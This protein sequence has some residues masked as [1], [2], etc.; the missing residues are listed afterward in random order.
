M[1]FVTGSNTA[2]GNSSSVAAITTAAITG[3][4]GKPVIAYHVT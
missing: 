3:L 1:G 2:A 4:R